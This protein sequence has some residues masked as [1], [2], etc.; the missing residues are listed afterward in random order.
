MWHAGEKGLTLESFLLDKAKVVDWV[1]FQ[2]AFFNMRR[3]YGLFCGERLGAALGEFLF[4][5]QEIF[6]RFPQ[7][8]IK[9]LL[10]LAETRLG[11]LRKL[12]S[13]G[14]LEVALEILEAD[15]ASVVQQE[16]FH[17]A[18]KPK[19]T[20][21]IGVKRAL[22]DVNG[23][24]APSGGIKAPRMKAPGMAPPLTGK[25]P[26]WNWIMKRS[27]C[28]GGTCASVSKRGQATPRPHVFEDAD[29]G[30]PEQAYRAWV[31]QRSGPKD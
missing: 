1:S 15:L 14:E 3:T 29:K 6:V 24:E 7:M 18:T 30:K 2:R 26:C 16:L 12:S 21:L 20:A 4:R 22:E 19:G 9:T 17:R 8:E 27:G 28:G 25:P 11:C 23:T 5:L 31:K 10:F 13:T